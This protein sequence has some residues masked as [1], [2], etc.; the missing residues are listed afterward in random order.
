LR[1]WS[2]DDEFCYLMKRVCMRQRTVCSFTLNGS[3]TSISNRNRNSNSN[4]TVTVTVTVIVTVTVLL[5]IKI[6][7]TVSVTFTVTVKV[8][9]TVTVRYHCGGWSEEVN[10]CILIISYMVYL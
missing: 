8:T 3:K 1:N 2:A 10:S 6:I 4:S 5:T 9:V 7:V